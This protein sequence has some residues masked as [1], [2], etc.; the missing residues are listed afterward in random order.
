MRP[1]TVH[2]VEAVVQVVDPGFELTVYEEIDAPP[3]PAGASHDTD[4]EESSAPSAD[5]PVGASATVEG[6]IEAEAVDAEPVPDTFVAVT[7]N[8]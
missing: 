3:L 8:V 6:T 2:E 7:V 1:V 5:T 4:A